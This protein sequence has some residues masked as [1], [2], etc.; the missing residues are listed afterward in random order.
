M[1]KKITSIII[2]IAIFATLITAV[3]TVS[4]KEQTYGT[5]DNFELGY[6]F[7]YLDPE[8]TTIRIDGFVNLDKLENKEYPQTINIPN[9][10]GK[11]VTTSI[12]EFAF[13]NVTSSAVIIP[14]TVTTIGMYAFSKSSLKEVTIPS[15]VKTLEKHAFLNC[16]NLTKVTITSNI[17][18]MGSNMFEGCSSLIEM[19]LAPNTTVI[20]NTTFKDCTSL[21]KID[22]PS[23]VKK[24][25][26][27]A[28]LNCSSLDSI[29]IPETVE[30]IQTQAVGYDGIN[31]KKETFTIFGKSDTEAERYAI[32]NDI[33]FKT[34]TT[35]LYGDVDNDG[36]I[37]IFDGVIVNMFLAKKVLIQGNDYKAADVNANGELDISDVMSIQLYL[38][39]KIYKFV[40]GTSFEY[41]G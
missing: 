8:L 28:F 26:Y 18:N 38:S 15:K 21:S 13:D 39:K 36:K 20:R 41:V 5:F 27:N 30:M 10:I 29:Y 22:I 1:K 12:K 16:K 11:A 35:R 23:S 4:A 14:D 31:Q 6:R 32:A 24:I 2:A 33:D 3:P 37:K 17:E 7:S 34:I 40:A 9:K 19:N 25:E